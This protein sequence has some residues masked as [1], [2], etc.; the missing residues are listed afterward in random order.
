MYIFV[1]TSMGYFS[2]KYLLMTTGG[3]L[4]LD[5]K[6]TGK[7]GKGLLSLG[8]DDDVQVGVVGKYVWMML[9]IS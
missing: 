4:V 9:L 1:Y 8:I 2:D 3:P 6:K 5:N 7:V